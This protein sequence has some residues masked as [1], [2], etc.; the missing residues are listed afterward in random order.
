MFE[1]SILKVAESYDET[2]CCLPNNTTHKQQAKSVFRNFEDTEV[3]RYWSQYQGCTFMEL[4]FGH[5]SH[6]C[7]KAMVFAN[8]NAGFHAVGI[9]PCDP[10]V[11]HLNL[12]LQVL[13]LRQH[14]QRML[15]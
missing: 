6:L 8:I 15:K 14:L 10:G 9:L 13:C 11:Y 3:F 2:L 4:Q 7:D 12:M 5:N 1:R